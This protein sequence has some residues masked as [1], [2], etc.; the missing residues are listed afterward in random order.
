MIP[1]SDPNPLPPN[2]INTITIPSPIHVEPTFPQDK[3]DTKVPIILDKTCRIKKVRIIEGKYLFHLGIL[4][5]ML[6][7]WGIIIPIL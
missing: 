7:Y 1:T 3:R 6:I 2:V 5:I 4:L